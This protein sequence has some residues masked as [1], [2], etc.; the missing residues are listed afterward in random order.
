MPHYKF[1]LAGKCVFD[2]AGR[3]AIYRVNIKPAHGR[4]P[5]EMALQPPRGGASNSELLCGRDRV[6][7]PA[8]IRS[9][10]ITN[11]NEHQDEALLRNQ[12]NL[13]RFATDIPGNNAQALRNKGLMSQALCPCA[14]MLGRRLS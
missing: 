12:V 13:A 2:P 6:N 8:K 4:A 11:F 1:R 9:A 3:F 7:G 10:S 14:P 5:L